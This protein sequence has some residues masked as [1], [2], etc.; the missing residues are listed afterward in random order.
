MDVKTLNVTLNKGRQRGVT[1]MELMIATAILAIIITVAVPSFSDIGDTQRLVGAAEQIFGHIQQTRSE[2]V[3]GNTNAYIKFDTDGTASWEYGFST[4]SGT[5][6]LTVTSPTT[7][8]A[9]V[10]V[11]DDGDG[12]I[13]PGDGSL[14]T[15]DLLLNRF[16]STEWIDVKASIASFSSGTTQINFDPVRGTSSDGEINLESG[17]GKRLRV[18]VSLL[19]RPKICNPSPTITVSNYSGC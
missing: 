16:T 1:L 9:C 10:T 18:E 5:C 4:V 15:G 19:G 3:S 11:V 7:A 13:D 6:D 12:L 2:S 14:D 17:N 8:N